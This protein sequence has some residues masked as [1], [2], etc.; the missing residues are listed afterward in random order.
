MRDNIVSVSPRAVIGWVIFALVHAGGLGLAVVSPEM[1]GSEPLTLEDGVDAVAMLGFGVLGAALVRRRVA[2]GLGA[3]L[4]LLA[5]LAA[6]NYLLAGLAQAI[7]NGE[8]GPPAVAQV[9]SLAAD[10]AFIISFFL[11]ILAPMLLFPT[12]RL[13]SGRWR[14]PAGAAVVGCVVSVLAMLMTPGP[15][16][17]DNPAWGVNPIGLDALSGVAD[18]LELLGVALLL[19]GLVTGIAAFGTR[20]CVTAAPDAGS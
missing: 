6:G 19:V 7:A 9:C 18:A 1:V 20:W 3:A 2:V 8:P 5:N 15:V 17:E 4:V 16:D 12:G 11:F 13:P 14:W 10:A